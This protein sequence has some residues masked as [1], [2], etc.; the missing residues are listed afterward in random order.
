MFDAIEAALKALR[1]TPAARVEELVV[2]TGGPDGCRTGAVQAVANTIRRMTRTTRVEIQFVGIALDQATTLRL[3]AQAEQLN[4]LVRSQVADVS[5]PR[6]AAQ[7]A[8][9]FVTGS[10]AQSGRAPACGTE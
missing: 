8:R 10:Q 1:Q 5:T 6:A 7:Q 3:D 9:G 2:I 4:C